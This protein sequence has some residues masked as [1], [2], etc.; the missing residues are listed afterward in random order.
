M[1][2][3]VGLSST[4]AISR[5]DPGTISA[6]TAQNAADDG[7][8]GTTICRGR[9]SA[10]PVSEMTRPSGVASTVSSAPKP[11]SIRSE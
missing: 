8:P 11:H 1:P 6:A 10:S 4:L 7:S 9:S 2:A 3:R 5:S